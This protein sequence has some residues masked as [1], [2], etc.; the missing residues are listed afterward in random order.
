LSRAG[1]WLGDVFIPEDFRTPGLVD[2]D[3]FHAFPI[4]C[5]WYRI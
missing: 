2:S 1:R 3:G 5:G 4:V